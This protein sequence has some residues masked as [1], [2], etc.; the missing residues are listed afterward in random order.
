MDSTLTWAM[1]VG[2]GVY[3]GVDPAMG[4]LAAAGRGLQQRAARPVIATV[5]AL[6]LG[7]Y[8]A[9]ISVL[10][11]VALLMIW[12][13]LH[14]AVHFGLFWP[15]PMMPVPFLGA[16]LAAFG[17]FKLLH[18]RHP[19]LLARIRPDRRI[20]WSFAAAVVH[21]GSPVMMLLPFLAL[22]APLATPLCGA[23]GMAFLMLPLALLVPAVMILPLF[24]VA[25]TIGLVVWR[26]L[27]LRALT[28][29]WI[30]FDIG[31]AVMNLMMAWMAV[32]MVHNHMRMGG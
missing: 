9:M 10:L 17:L 16:A 2:M 27:G 20:R 26:Y 5:A 22:A 14:P 32:T 8:L 15:T 31:W 24:V 18:P 1:I 21:C 4:W 7:H 13:T 19:A 12:M 30:N 29:F 28:R 25:G 11:P 23:R 6:A 3:Q